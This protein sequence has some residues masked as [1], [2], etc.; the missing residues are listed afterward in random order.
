MASPRPATRDRTLSP[1]AKR[2]AA[3][4]SADKPTLDI[5]T[6]HFRQGKRCRGRE[7]T[8]SKKPCS[9]WHCMTPRALDILLF[10]GPRAQWWPPENDNET[11][12]IGIRLNTM[13]RTPTKNTVKRD[14]HETANGRHRIYLRRP[15]CPQVALPV[16]MYTPEFWSAYHAAMSDGSSL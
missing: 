9:A 3:G 13:R 8:R 1:L 2:A 7:Y 14:I 4:K 16:P 5:S 10:H 15:G 11:Q 12:T 6:S